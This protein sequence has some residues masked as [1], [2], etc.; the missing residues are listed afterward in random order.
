LLNQHAISR[1]EFKIA[2]ALAVREADAIRQL[3]AT[4]FHGQVAAVHAF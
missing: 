2:G 3:E 4:S 1:R